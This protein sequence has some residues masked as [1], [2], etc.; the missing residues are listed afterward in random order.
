MKPSTMKVLGML[1]QG[2][3]T[4]G[5]FA[6]AFCPRASARIAELREM[7]YT[8]RTRQLTPSAFEYDLVGSPP[9]PTVPPI[10]PMAEPPSSASLSP[11]Q[12][13]AQ[14]GTLFDTIDLDIP[15]PR[16]PYEVEAV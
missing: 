16:G 10:P 14:L 4:T 5:E 3:V 15:P 12:A 2:P 11:E 1:Q 7:G 13:Q 9:D 6:A 8:I